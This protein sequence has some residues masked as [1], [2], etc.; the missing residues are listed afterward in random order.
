MVVGRQV[1]DWRSLWSSAGTSV[2]LDDV[3]AVSNAP[4]MTS[5]RHKLPILIFCSV[6]CRFEFERRCRWNV[7]AWLY[8][9][10]DAMAPLYR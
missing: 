1:A 5:C 10:K 7:S 3:P 4:E 2:S 8:E 9:V 6:N